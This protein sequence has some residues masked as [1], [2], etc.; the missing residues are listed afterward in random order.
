MAIIPSKQNVA[1]LA[2]PCFRH[3]QPCHD[4][5]SPNSA[6]TSDPDTPAASVMP[7]R[8]DRLQY[9]GCPY[10]M[11]VFG[12]VRDGCAMNVVIPGNPGQAAYYQ[13]FCSG[14]EAQ[15]LQQ[16]RSPQASGGG[17]RGRLWTACGQRRVDS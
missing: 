9:K 11:E 7:R 13:K 4:C 14:L 16:G 8:V 3:P 12:T 6:T 1:V 2:R 17:Q 15:V 5:I 10:D